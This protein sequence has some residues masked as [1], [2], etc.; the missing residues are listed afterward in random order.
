MNVILSIRPKYVR[1]IEL[2]TKLYE[3]RKVRFRK[4]IERVYIYAT[5]PTQRIVGRFD[6]GKIIE[7]HPKS[8]W[9]ALYQVAGMSEVDFFTYYR[10]SD[11]GLAI[12]IKQVLFFQSPIDPKSLSRDF[13][14]PQSFR[15]V[16]GEAISHVGV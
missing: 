5:S 7:G 11:M 4:D 13:S 15:Y 16:S 2:G 9:E 10:Q 14:P 12:E 3:F 8:L 6:V 1:A